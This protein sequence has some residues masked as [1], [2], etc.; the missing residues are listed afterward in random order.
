MVAPVNCDWSP[1]TLRVSFGVCPGETAARI[2][3]MSLMVTGVSGDCNIGLL[4]VGVAGVLVNGSVAISEKL[5]AS[6]LSLK[7]SLLMLTASFKWLSFVAF[8]SS[9]ARFT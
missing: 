7:W 6:K 8:A 4:V 5:V 3:A 2:A 9:I 1:A